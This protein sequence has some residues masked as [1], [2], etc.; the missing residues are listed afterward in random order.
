M[1]NIKLKIN[2]KTRELAVRDSELLIEML[3]DRLGLLGTKYSCLEGDCGVCTVLLD[4]K[5]VLSCLIL[6]ADADGHEVTTIEGIAQKGVL[7]PLQESFVKNGAIQCGF[8]TPGM[9]LAAKA[10][11]DKDPSP[12]DG[13]IAS[14]LDGNLCRCTGYIKIIDAVRQASQRL[15]DGK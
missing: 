1:K 6:A 9:I 4:G 3:R 10:L 5:N 11:L 12:T 2:N 8:C 13:E 7:H 14:G 15:K